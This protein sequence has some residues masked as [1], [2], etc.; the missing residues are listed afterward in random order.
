MIC[1]LATN[2]ETAVLALK[3]PG[4]T[5]TDVSGASDLREAKRQCIG[6]AFATL[7]IS[8]LARMEGEGNLDLSQLD[9]AARIDI[10]VKVAMLMIK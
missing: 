4:S 8:E 9:A 2:H 3:R 5:Q 7:D 1:D 10:I 6:S